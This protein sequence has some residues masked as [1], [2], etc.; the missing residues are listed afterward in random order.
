MSRTMPD[1]TPVPRRKRPTVDGVPKER[2]RCPA[3]RKALR[4][5]YTSFRA[6]G[7]MTYNVREAT[8]HRFDG[9]E[10]YPLSDPTFDTLQC[11]M[12]FGYVALGEIRSGS[13]K[14]LK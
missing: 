8:A 11:G 5:R 2:P 12:M 9:W 10:G 4:V 6:D 7:S 3:C 14:R 1:G 13:P